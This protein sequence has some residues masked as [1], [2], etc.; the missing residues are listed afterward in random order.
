MDI[1]KKKKYENTSLVD[2]PAAV[3]RVLSNIVRGQLENVRWEVWRFSIRIR[4]TIISFRKPVYW[5]KFDVFVHTATKCEQMGAYILRFV[6]T[7]VR[8]TPK[9]SDTIPN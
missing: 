2:S 4:I 9:N 3:P 7:S 5:V 6:L 8:I 1:P